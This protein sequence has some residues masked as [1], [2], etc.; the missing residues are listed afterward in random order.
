MAALGRPAGA[1]SGYEEHAPVGVR[2][3]DGNAI[4]LDDRPIGKGGQGTVYR[5]RHTRYA[6]KLTDQ[7]MDTSG[8]LAER[9]ARLRWL[10]LENLPIS[11]PIKPLAEPHTG[12]IMDLLDG[13][14][15]IASLCEPPNGEM[16]PW[17]LAGGGLRRRLRLLSRCAG[18]LAALHGRGLVYGDLS[19]G[20]VLVSSSADQ[21]QVWLIDPDN[22]AIESS[23]R[24]RV[25]E[26]R[27]Y[28]APE[29]VRRQ[30]GNTPFS[31]AYS[32]AILAYQTLRGDHPLIGDTVEES[33]QFEDDV[34]RG[35]LPWAG[36]TTDT[37]NRSG[38]GLPV[39][40]VLT[41][42]LQALFEQNF[43]EGLNDPLRRPTAGAWASALNTAAELTVTCPSSGC[44]HSY[45]VYAGHCPFCRAGLPDLILVGIRE[46]IPGHLGLGQDSKPVI[47][48]PGG[49]IVLQAGEPTVVTAR[50]SRLVAE[51]TDLPVLRLRWPGGASVHIENLGRAPV[52]RVPPAGG[53]GRTL[54][55]GA[56]ASQ[57]IEAGWRVHFG[58]DRRIHRLLAFHQPMGA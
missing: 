47:T 18:I 12:Y 16:E 23:A 58:D 11:R 41:S 36:H 45:Y 35:L 33:E 1:F 2:D 44:R 15:P 54:L 24:D 22:I 14:E 51:D 37:R 4:E 55:P 57:P 17:Y 52:R 28:R 25:A 9:F 8:S 34:E 39:Q 13:I 10:P 50:H 7:R 46:Q 3:I 20:N 48:E 42:R 49:W 43:E 19:P 40:V 6:A 21:L 32:F 29:I 5:V 27:L 31:D 53:T 30:T 56:W 38:Y 26:T